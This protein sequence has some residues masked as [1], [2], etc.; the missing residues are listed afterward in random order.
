V[1]AL[2]EIVEEGKNGF[3]FNEGD[4]ETIAEK[5]EEL[6]ANKKLYRE[7][8]NRNQKKAKQ[9]GWDSILEQ[10]IKIYEELAKEIEGS[11]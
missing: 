7:I 5:I 8:S 2:P 3:L 10:Y 1:G 11:G 6:K 9:Y 4:D